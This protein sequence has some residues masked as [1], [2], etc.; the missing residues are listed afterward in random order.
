MDDDELLRQYTGEAHPLSDEALLSQYSADNPP[1]TTQL[2]AVKRWQSG[3]PYGQ[4]SKEEQTKV[5]D[6]ATK[7]AQD[8]GAGFTHGAM[9]IPSGRFRHEVR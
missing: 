9:K 4:L 1:V 5:N 8:F 6:Y 7:N 3:T 2:D